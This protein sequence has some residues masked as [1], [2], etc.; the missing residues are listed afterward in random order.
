MIEYA[1]ILFDP[2]AFNVN[3]EEFKAYSELYSKTII[4]HGKEIVDCIKSWDNGESEYKK[5]IEILDRI[6]TYQGLLSDENNRRL[7][8]ESVLKYYKF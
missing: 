6:L 8:A 2:A 5:R 1:T 7:I 3:T 4:E